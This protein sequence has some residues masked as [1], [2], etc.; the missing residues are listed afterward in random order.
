MTDADRLAA[1]LHAYITTSGFG[2]CVHSPENEWMPWCEDFAG[3]LIAAGVTL[4]PPAP[5][6]GLREALG[7]ASDDHRP[8][9][10]WRIDAALALPALRRRARRT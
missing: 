2:S 3:N 6:E 8:R 7:T 4:Q 9:P 10:G 5:A 1:L